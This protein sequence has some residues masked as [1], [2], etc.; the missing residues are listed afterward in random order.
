M[1]P[2]Y[3]SDFTVI[4]ENGSWEEA[5]RDAQVSWTRTCKRDRSLG[6]LIV[7]MGHH[8]SPKMNTVPQCRAKIIAPALASRWVQRA[9]CGDCVRIGVN[10]E[11]FSTAGEPLPISR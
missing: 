2:C 4:G 8:A 7:D 11:G 5:V 3:S 1:L 10:N 6:G 9:G